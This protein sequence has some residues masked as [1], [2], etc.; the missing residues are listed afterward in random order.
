LVVAVLRAHHEGHLDPRHPID[1]LAATVHCVDATRSLLRYFGGPPWC[2]LRPSPPTDRRVPSP[3]FGGM[4]DRPPAAVLTARSVIAGILADRDPQVMVQPARDRR[5]LSG[6]DGVRAPLWLAPA[7]KVDTMQV[8]FG[9]GC[10]GS[11]VAHRGSRVV[12]RAASWTLS[13]GTTASS[14]SGE[15]RRDARRRTLL[16]EVVCSESCGEKGSW[17]T[18]LGELTREPV[19]NGGGPRQHGRRGR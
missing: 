10:A 19:V 14:A 7:T 17:W 3:H 16:R 4:P 18:L 13:N 5:P 9:R 2:D 15:C 11:V 12:V 1:R 8:A 6:R